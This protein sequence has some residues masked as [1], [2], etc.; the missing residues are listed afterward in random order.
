LE[1]LVWKARQ[2][3]APDEAL[4]AVNAAN[5]KVTSLQAR[6]GSTAH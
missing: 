6:R 3:S 2:Q 5:P 1:D 4:S